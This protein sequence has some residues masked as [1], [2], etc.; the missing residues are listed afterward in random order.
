MLLNSLYPLC[1]H[2]EIQKPGF[3]NA[4]EIKKITRELIKREIELAEKEGRTLFVCRD[5]VENY[6][7][8]GADN[9]EVVFVNMNLMP[10]ELY[11]TNNVKITVIR[12]PSYPAEKTRLIIRHFANNTDYSSAGEKGEFAKKELIGIGEDNEIIFINSG[13]RGFFE[14]NKYVIPYSMNPVIREIE[15]GRYRT[16]MHESTKFPGQEYWYG[17]ME[18]LL[19]E[20]NGGKK[21]ESKVEERDRETE[22]FDTGY[23]DAK[24]KTRGTVADLMMSRYSIARPKA[25]MIQ[26]ELRQTIHDLSQTGGM[27]V[28]E[29]IQNACESGAS[30]L[31][32]KFDEKQGVFPYQTTETE[33]HTILL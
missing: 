28:T 31:E 30:S 25:A 5:T 1:Q 18:D 19:E 6:E 8:F 32:I 17:S 33:C 27:F 12:N 21:D 16:R 7:F 3:V 10:K 4:V 23:F 2:F 14:K 29:L 11:Y 22:Y 9:P 15:D 26:N 13:G 24:R 20:I